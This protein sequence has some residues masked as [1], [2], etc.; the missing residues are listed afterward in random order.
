[1]PIPLSDDIP[2]LLAAPNYVH[3]STLRA[4]GSPRNWVVWVGTDGDHIL[5]CASESVEG[6]GRACVTPRHRLSVADPANPY[7]MVTLQGRVVDIRRSGRGL[8]PYGPD[9]SEV[10]E[11]SFPSRWPDRM[12]FPRSLSRRHTT[13]R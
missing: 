13:V 7:R 3:L 5:A 6:Q 2:E 12:C 10:H 9:L 11:R 1:M 8:P 4:D